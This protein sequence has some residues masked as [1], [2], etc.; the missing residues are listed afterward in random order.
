MKFT[1]SS[2]KEYL[3]TNASLDEICEKLTFIGLEVESIT[4]QSKILS[5]FS[6][7]KIIECKNHDN[8]DKLKICNVCVDEKLPNLQIVCGASN[9][10]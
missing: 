2:L 4:D 9:A 1:L 3:E 7:A 8:S 6:V 10:R 5:Q